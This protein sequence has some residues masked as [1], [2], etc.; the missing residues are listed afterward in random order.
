MRMIPAK[1]LR[2][3]SNAEIHMF[4]Q[5]RLSFSG[6]D[7]NGWEVVLVDMPAPGHGEAMC[8][9]HHIGMSGARALFSMICC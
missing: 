9:F 4:D 7:R 6:A 8:S 1:P 2:T 5:L 3:G